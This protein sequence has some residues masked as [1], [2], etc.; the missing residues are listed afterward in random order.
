MLWVLTHKPCE[1]SLGFLQPKH[2]L[3]GSP[4]PAPRQLLELQSLCWLPTLCIAVSATDLWKQVTESHSRSKL[5]GR[6]QQQLINQGHCFPPD[7]TESPQEQQGS[8]HPVLL[9]SWAVRG[10]ILALGLADKLGTRIR[11]KNKHEIWERRWQHLQSSAR[12]SSTI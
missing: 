6:G 9:V 1:L 3:W 4:A 8:Q 12:H 2:H 7:T 11:M 5:F 10:H